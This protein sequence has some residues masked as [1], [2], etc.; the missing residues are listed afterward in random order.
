MCVAALASSQR[1]HLPDRELGHRPR[2]HDAS[3]PR[4]TNAAPRLPTSCPEP[5]GESIFRAYAGVAVLPAAE[6]GRPGRSASRLRAGFCSL[7]QPAREAGGG[8]GLGGAARAAARARDAARG[9]PSAAGAA[10]PGRNPGRGEGPA[11][12]KV[13]PSPGAEISAVLR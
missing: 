2:R 13:P 4:V 5:R 11:P 3:S 6:P 10:A 1:S 8:R 7:D 12:L 9:L